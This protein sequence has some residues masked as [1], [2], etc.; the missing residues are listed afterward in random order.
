MSWSV[1]ALILEG[2]RVH[3]EHRQTSV[4]PPYD[5]PTLS[6]APKSVYCFKLNPSCLQH[7]PLFAPHCREA[8]MLSKG[9]W[10]IMVHMKPPGLHVKERLWW[11]VRNLTFH[12]PGRDIRQTMCVPPPCCALLLDLFESLIWLVGWILD[13][14]CRHNWRPLSELGSSWDGIATLGRSIP[15]LPGFARTSEIVITVFL[16]PIASARI[17]KRKKHLGHLPPQPC[18]LPLSLSLSRH[19]SEQTRLPKFTSKS[20]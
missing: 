12:W 8:P 3:S 15:P 2:D 11:L 16:G 4:L 10:T 17:R 6:A 20:I 1:R 9:T 13:S 5:S 19:D 7:H 14:S 18:I